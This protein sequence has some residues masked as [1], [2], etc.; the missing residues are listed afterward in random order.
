MNPSQYSDVLA[1]LA[2]Y[3]D[4]LY[5]LDTAK[6]REVFSPSAHYATIAQGELLSLSIDQYLP[7]VEQRQPPAEAGTPYE[8]RVTA[9]RFAGDDTAL[10]EVECSLF[11]HEYRDF[12]SLLR[13]DGRWRIQAKVFQGTPQ[14]SAQPSQEGR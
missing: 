10:A 1:L 8:S 7:R 4:G 3:Y 11:G 2:D 6:L 13:I 9:I 5:R 14:Q 12:L